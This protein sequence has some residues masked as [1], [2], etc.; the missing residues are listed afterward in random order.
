[1]EYSLD[2]GFILFPIKIL[3]L[4]FTCQKKRTNKKELG[5]IGMDSTGFSIKKLKR[6]IIFDY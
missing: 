1:M 3:G 6:I 2:G 5:S 4:Y